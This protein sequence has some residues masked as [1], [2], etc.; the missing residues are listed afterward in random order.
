M[1]LSRRKKQAL[2]I[3]TFA[4]FVVGSALAL[5]GFVVFADMFSQAAS[6]NEPPAPGTGLL[7]AVVLTMVSS[8]LSV[9]LIAIYVYLAAQLQIDSTERI[10]WIL[11]VVL[12]GT[13]GQIVFFFL[14]VWPEPNVT[15]PGSMA[16]QPVGQPTQV[17]GWPT[18]QV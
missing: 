3:C 2:G 15:K 6:S 12:G 14:R 11:V 1:R 5:V 9:A 17:S 18:G 8:V 16:T 7:V 10:V 4:S 13:I